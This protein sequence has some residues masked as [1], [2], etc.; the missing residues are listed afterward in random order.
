VIQ[1]S[2]KKD[3]RERW[4]RAAARMYEAFQAPS[5]D[6]EQD[7]YRVD[8]APVSF[9]FMDSR[10][11][12]KQDMARAFAANALHTIE[13]WVARLNQNQLVGVFVTGQPLLAPKVGDTRGSVADWALANYR[14]HAS[15]M[16]A[17][18]RCEGPLVLL[19]GDVHY[20][21]VCEA[22]SGRRK[23]IEVVV[24]PLSLVKTDLR[25]N[26][27]G[28]WDWVT[29]LFGRSD[30]WPRHAK[31]APAPRGV[32][33]GRRFDFSE[34][35][36]GEAGKGDQV[37]VLRFSRDAGRVKLDV[38][39]FHVQTAAENPRTISLLA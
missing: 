11:K 32:K 17:L 34:R 18:G 25:D 10:S 23:I 31:P 2:W 36:G 28:V 1:N 22:G 9:L 6:S 5:G 19:T 30:P 13:A 35:M 24:S 8:V 4:L 26:A 21:R 33:L 16:S 38:S 14:D 27:A 12:R 37:A 3:S 7:S 39:Y 29:G 20:N 15:V